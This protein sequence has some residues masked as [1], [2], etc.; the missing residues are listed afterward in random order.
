M[1]IGAAKGSL[2]GVILHVGNE[3]PSFPVFDA[4]QT[5]IIQEYETSPQ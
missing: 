1:F 5:N 4:T 2:N 3:F